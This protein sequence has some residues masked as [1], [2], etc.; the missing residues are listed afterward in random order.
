[1][2]ASPIARSL[3][4]FL[5]NQKMLLFAC[6]GLYEVPVAGNPVCP[7]VD[8]ECWYVPAQLWVSGSLWSAQ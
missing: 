4:S 3:S 6:L 8:R 1:M 7:V 2:T 5:L